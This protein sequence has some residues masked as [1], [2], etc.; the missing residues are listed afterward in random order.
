[1]QP[2]ARQETSKLTPAENKC[3]NLDAQLRCMQTA[4]P[5]VRAEACLKG[6]AAPLQHGHAQ[7]RLEDLGGAE[8]LQIL[9]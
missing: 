8:A 7:L 6:A 3:R 5:R 4:D 2:T 1:M 9:Q